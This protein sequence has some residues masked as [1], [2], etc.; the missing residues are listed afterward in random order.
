MPFL[1]ES[2]QHRRSARESMDCA[3]D[4]ARNWPALGVK[5][6]ITFDAHDPA[7]AERH[8]ADGL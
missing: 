7:G 2:R 8:P 3:T 5:N 1:Y 6:I 4:A